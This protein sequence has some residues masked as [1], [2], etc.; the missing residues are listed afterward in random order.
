MNIRIDPKQA[1]NNVNALIENADKL[2]EM[3]YKEG[4]RGKKQLDI[5]IVGFVRAVFIDD[6]EKLDDYY[7]NLNHGCRCTGNDK[8][9]AEIKPD[10]VIKLKEK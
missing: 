8:Q 4:S 6:N 9:K 3:S 7:F 1:L 2:L 5:E 10:T